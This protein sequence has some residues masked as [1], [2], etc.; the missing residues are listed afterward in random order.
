MKRFLYFLTLLAVGMLMWFF[1]KPVYQ[2]LT[3]TFVKHFVLI[4]ISASLLILGFIAF[5]TFKFRKVRKPK[6]LDDFSLD[7]ETR[8]NTKIDIGV[9]RKKRAKKIVFWFSFLTLG[10][11]YVLYICLRLLFYEMAKKDNLVTLRADGEIKAIMRGNEC[12]RYIMKVENNRIDPDGFDLF[13]GSFESYAAYLAKALEEKK[14]DPGFTE[15]KLKV[16]EQG[17]L[18]NEFNKPIVLDAK[19]NPTN[20]HYQLDQK[21]EKDIEEANSSTLFEEIFGVF[22]VGLP[23]YHVFTYQFRWLKYGQQ[24]AQDGQPSDKVDIFARDEIVDSLFYRYPQYGVVVK[25]AE[26]GAG[27]LGADSTTK[28]GKK[29]LT[30]VQVTATFVFETVT[31]NP[32]KTLFRTAALSSAGD[33]QQALGR[34]IHDRVRMWLGGT[35]W[36]SL[37]SDKKGVEDALREIRDSINGVDKNDLPLLDA[38]ISSV[39]DYGQRI[40]KITMPEVDLIGEGLQKAYEDVF[41]AEKKRDA[42]I[43]DAAGKRALAAA[44]ILGK[45][46]GLKEIGSI[47]GGKEM[48]M[49]EQLGRIHFYAPG[50]DGLFFNIAEEV[51]SGSRS[52]TKKTKTTDSP[53]E[54]EKGS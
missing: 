14:K 16:D 39:R 17:N 41:R 49:S 24:K 1:L 46:D 44:P 43:A 9:E 33:W 2:F 25:D 28:D 10:S 15:R 38:Q 12:I 34:E 31:T 21:L 6:E 20:G 18:L 8:D 30:K 54:D 32:Q 40:V 45:A 26:T 37:V 51:T 3:N 7:D 19:G 23:P 13:K 47:P 42:D 27:S 22:W 29:I 11:G 52:S 5:L 35:D 36:D 4:S 48:F 53:D 50:R